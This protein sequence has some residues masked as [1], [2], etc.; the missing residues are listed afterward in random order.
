VLTVLAIARDVTDIR[1]LERRQ[2]QYFAMAPGL[3]ATLLKRTDGSYKMSFVSD[4]IRDLYG[5]EP[6]VVTRNISAFV[7]LSHPDDIDMIFRKARQSANDLIPFH[8]EYRIN[9]PTKG[10]RWIECHAMPQCMPDGGLRWDGFCHDITARKKMEEALLLSNKYL[11]EAQRIGQMGSWALD[12]VNGR[13]S[14]S[15]E[16]YRI[17]EISPFDSRASYEVF[18]NVVH[19][20]D[21]MAV[22]KAYRDSLENRADYSI[23]HRLLFADGRIKYVRECC[24]TDYD[25]QGQPVCSTG[26]IQD[27]TERRESEAA[28]RESEE[29]LRTLYEMFPLG[30][31]MTDMQGRYLEFNEAFRAICGYPA[32]ELKSLD[33]WTLTPQEYAAKE[34]E[35]LKSL[36][37]IGRYGPYEK[38]YLQKDGSR[39]PIQLNGV[40]VTGRDGQ[41]YIW[42]IVEDISNRKRMEVALIEREREFRTLAENSLDTVV[43]FDRECRF[44]Y[45]NPEYEKSTGLQLGQLF[46]MR[47]TQIPGLPAAEF[48]QQ[49]VQQV[50]ETGRA[51][52]FECSVSA[53]EDAADWRLVSI[54]PELDVAGQVVYIQVLS[55]NIAALKETQQ[56]LEESRAQLRQLLAHQE[57]S[58]ESVRKKI[59]WDMHE[60]LLQVLSVL[61]MYAS[62]LK[63]CVSDSSVQQTIQALI[64]GLDSSTALVRQMVFTLRPPVLN[65]GV[66]VALEWLTNAFIQQH[67]EMGCKL[68]VAAD[69]LQMDEK[70]V[71]VVFRIV[72]ESLTFIAKRRVAAQVDVKL[73]RVSGDYLLSVSEENLGCCVDFSGE[74]AL[75]LLGLQEHVLAMGGEM[76]LSGSQGLI[77]E[78]RL[79]VK[80]SD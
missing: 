41:K 72:Q 40:L 11:A 67:A 13:L 80:N 4:G 14:W 42:S 29:K 79:P 61:R 39:V 66:M 36:A 69:I 65:Q 47:P 38:E 12:L 60:E 24:K 64:S 45:V 51:D 73:V 70:S 27:I 10:L 18:L 28:L 30:I 19:P 5:I 17:C 75:S 46:G 16:V 59:S 44:V 71:L 48:F 2:S 20:D 6:D 33:Y 76:R 1:R 49:R 15:E 63:S 57:N 77:I 54:F 7:A 37:S 55:R 21:R 9:H 43:R 52:E 34:D 31:A 50:I 53:Q 22:N 23:D 56:Y 8:V 35:Q 26:T 78:A 74:D 32:D 25:A 68:T 3:F 58:H 62:M